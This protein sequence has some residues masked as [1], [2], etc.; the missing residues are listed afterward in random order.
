MEA[1][2]LEAHEG[3]RWSSHSCAWVNSGWCQPKN[4][5][6]TI[7]GFFP[8]KK[9]LPTLVQVAKTCHLLNNINFHEMISLPR[10]LFLLKLSLSKQLFIMECY[11]WNNEQP[12]IHKCYSKFLLLFPWKLFFGNIV[13]IVHV[14]TNIFFSSFWKKR[15]FGKLCTDSTF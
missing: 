3:R 13:L 2:G 4:L 8:R 1:K 10:F 6:E 5:V 15:Q 12:K 9:H 11:Q 7:N 14:H